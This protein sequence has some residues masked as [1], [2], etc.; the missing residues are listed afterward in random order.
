MEK[1]SN[2]NKILLG[3]VIGLTIVTVGIVSILYGFDK[4]ASKN[5]L[6]K[7]DNKYATS[8]NNS[9]QKNDKKEDT[10]SL[11]NNENLNNENDE[12]NEK[13]ENTENNESNE[14]VNKEEIETE[15]N[16]E[17]ESEEV[18]EL[19][20]DS[21]NDDSLVVKLGDADLIDKTNIIS[22]S[23]LIDKFFDGDSD[24]KEVD[25]V[26]DYEELIEEPTEKPFP[27]LDNLINNEENN[28]ENNNNESNN[29][30]ENNNVDN[31]EENNNEEGNNEENNNEEN[32]NEPVLVEIPER[33]DLREKI[34]LTVEDQK[35]YG[36][37]WS[38]AS[39]KSLETNLALTTGEYYNFSEIHVD[40][41]TSNLMS[42]VNNSRN[43]HEGGNFIEFLKYN[44]A[45]GG[46]VNED[47]LEYRD[48][49]NQEI[50]TFYN[51]EKENIMVTDYI[52]FESYNPSM[53][54][55]W[56]KERFNEYQESIKEHIMKNG[57]IVMT[58]CFRDR[59]KINY[60]YS[61]ENEYNNIDSYH[62][63]SVIGWDDNYP[64]ENFISS[65]GEVPENDGAYIILNSWGENSGDNGYL[66]ISYEDYLVH[67]TMYGIISTNKNIDSLIDINSID[68]VNL[69]NGIKERY[70][71]SIVEQDGKE[72]V[73]KLAL[74]YING[75]NVLDCSNM[76][77]KSL[78]GIEL[79]DHVVEI[80]LS[81]NKL[82]SIE[83][84]G[85]LKNLVVVNLANNNIVDVSVLKNNEKLGFLNLANNMNV[86]GYEELTNL[87][88][89]NLSNCNVTDIS[90]I[91]NF[92][93][94][95]IL[96]LSGNKINLENDYLNNKKLYELYLD[97]C[98]LTKV[99]NLEKSTNLI[100]LDLSNNKNLVDY[101]ALKNIEKIEKL[102]LKNNNIKDITMLNNNVTTVD[103][104][105]NKEIF[106]I[107]ELTKISYL[108]MKNCDITDVSIF[109]GL[110][111]EE[112]DLS[113]NIGLTGILTTEIKSL[114]IENCNLD[115]EFDF[116]G[117]ESFDELSIYG[118]NISLDNLFNTISC[119]RIKCNNIKYTELD[120]VPKNVILYET[121]IVIDCNF[122]KENVNFRLIPEVRKYTLNKVSVESCENVEINKLFL[123]GKI[124]NDY[125]VVRIRIFANK[126]QSCYLQFNMNV[127]EKDI[128]TD[129]IITAMPY[130][131]N[132]ILGDHLDLTGLKVELVYLSGA[133]K[134]IT[135]YVVN[136]DIELVEGENIIDIYKDNFHCEFNVD[137]CM[138]L[139][140]DSIQLLTKVAE[141]VGEQ[142]IINQDIINKTLYITKQGENNI[143]DGYF[144]IE[145]SLLYDIGSLNKIK[146]SELFIVYDGHKINEEDIEKLKSLIVTDKI[147]IINTSEEKNE[148]I[149][150]KQDKIK[151]NFI[152]K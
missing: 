116:F 126:Y 69:V 91:E 81:N 47:K 32:N 74:N 49:T 43:V 2:L 82:E 53:K 92:D 130:K 62:N 75:F 1:K 151:F 146:F 94:I 150:V 99:P 80:D 84:L 5:S 96:N 39:L 79:F 95:E 121:N 8:N 56:G 13:V 52:Q 76:N 3:V 83:E 131:T 127:L 50:L 105:G 73:N 34:N 23:D 87:R 12:N 106:N 140:F 11:N 72:Y 68:N 103:L 89:L 109:D 107:N 101:S 64:K 58:Y 10:N 51:T 27:D 141:V 71:Y 19:E 40:Y 86:Q 144:E 46:V 42:V 120:K 66:Y 112:L 117:R 61:N 20:E 18:N 41:L 118:N 16:K 35:S 22:K 31:N 25:E 123:R 136:E 70:P 98:G 128:P 33:F 132:Y 148:N 124:L 21:E 113:E 26:D 114:K 119:N 97:N 44:F 138:K 24:Y 111:L 142:E 93:V 102:I 77:L 122:C 135:D 48:Y 104:S 108:I 28:N 59:N 145:S 60:Y 36:L 110:K 134:E 9:I 29:N 78:K 55:E 54:E 115:D 57:S 139:K 14:I 149:I 67:S 30:E 133:R 65:T 45:F 143:Y 90:F 147:H 129:M 17:N 88:E 125:G 7:E 137:C 6:N 38:F 100:V 15:E 63:M 37:C 85:S 4:A 152:N